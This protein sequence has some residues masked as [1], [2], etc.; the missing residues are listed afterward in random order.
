MSW[1]ELQHLLFLVSVVWVFGHF[2]VA[3]DMDA[4]DLGGLCLLLLLKDMIYE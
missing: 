1:V 4:I 2:N 3:S